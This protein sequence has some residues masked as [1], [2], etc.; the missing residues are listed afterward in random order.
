[1]VHGATYVHYSS[2]MCF[3][4][5]RHRVILIANKHL[6]EFFELPLPSEPRSHGGCRAGCRGSPAPA[7]DHRLAH[8]V[9]SL[10]ALGEGILAVL[11]LGCDGRSLVDL[12]LLY[13]LRGSV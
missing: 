12:A 10:L 7:L 11:E 13:I 2:C 1:M 4:L 5:S 9:L 8:L 3:V 6:I